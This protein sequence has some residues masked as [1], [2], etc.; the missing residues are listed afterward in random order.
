VGGRGYFECLGAE[1]PAAE[2]QWGSGAQPPEARG[3]GAKPPSV[4]SKE[5]WGR[6]LQLL[7]IF[8]IF[9]QNNAFLG[10]FRLKF[11]L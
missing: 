3:L 5:V 9:Q 4:G 2:S 6:S 11:L 7:A 10:I 1:P 8:T